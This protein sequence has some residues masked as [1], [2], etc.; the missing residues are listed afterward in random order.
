[1]THGYSDDK[2]ALARRLK[3]VEGQVRGIA[4]MIEG[5]RYCIDIVTQVQAASAA[6]ARVE[7]DLLKSHVR[8]CVTGAVT[9]N[10]AD[11]QSAKLRELINI[12]PKL[13]RG[14]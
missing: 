11:D 2:P 14:R 6:L 8:H 4:A 5:D 10:D 1:M 7:A 13:T 9:D 3:R 12:I